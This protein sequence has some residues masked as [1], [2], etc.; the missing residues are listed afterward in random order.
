MTWHHRA[1]K[2]QIRRDEWIPNNKI[3]VRHDHHV[4][5]HVLFDNFNAKKIC[6]RFERYWNEFGAKMTSTEDQNTIGLNNREKSW[7]L[8]FKGK[9]LDQIIFEINSIWLDPREL[10]TAR[11]I[12]VVV[13]S[14]IR[15]V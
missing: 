6:K 9:S 8:L 1:P 12:E 5:W 2:S 7:R 14:V 11:T 3:R 4:A 15:R 10:L 13:I